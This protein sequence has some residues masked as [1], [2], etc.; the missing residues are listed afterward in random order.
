MKGLTT[1]SPLPEHLEKWLVKKYR[2]DLLH[3]RQ[4]IFDPKTR[5]IYYYCKECANDNDTPKD[6]EASESA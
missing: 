1:T 2:C 6:K 5:Q 3:K 4:P